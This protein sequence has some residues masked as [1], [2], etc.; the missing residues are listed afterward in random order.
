MVFWSFRETELELECT[1][2]LFRRSSKTCKIFTSVEE[3]SFHWHYEWMHKRLMLTTNCES[4]FEI[5]TCF[6]KQ[7][8]NFNLDLKIYE[9]SLLRKSTSTL[10]GKFTHTLTFF[11]GDP[12]DK[13]HFLFWWRYHNFIFFHFPLVGCF[14]Q[15]QSH[16]IIQ[17]EK[18]ASALIQ[19]IPITGVPLDI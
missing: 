4:N 18:A 11:R 7:I 12:G 9:F 19:K 5:S 1:L 3:R 8:P 15:I 2:N 6:F 13:N 17:L 14:A 10:F 16:T